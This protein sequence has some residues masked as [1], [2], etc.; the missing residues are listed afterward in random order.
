MTNKALLR[1]SLITFRRKC[2]NP[3]CRC[4]KGELHESPALSV[5]AQDKSYLITLP[6]E[7]VGFVREAIT[8]YGRIY[9]DMEARVIKEIEA[10]Q[11][12]IGKA[13]GRSVGRKGRE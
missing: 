2:G 5:R 8:R 3:N 4:S 1:G 12:R 10:L 11:K 13:R 7:E 6:D 9:N